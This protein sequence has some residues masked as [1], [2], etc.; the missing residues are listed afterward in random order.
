ADRKWGETRPCPGVPRALDTRR[1]GE[2]WSECVRGADTVSRIGNERPSLQPSPAGGLQARRKDSG[3]YGLYPRS[4]RQHDC[5]CASKSSILINFEAM[6]SVTRQKWKPGVL[7]LCLLVATACGGGGG[8][9]ATG[10]DE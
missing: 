4:H 7:L 10:D 8:S 5:E 2:R 3:S 6:R 9:E 1:S